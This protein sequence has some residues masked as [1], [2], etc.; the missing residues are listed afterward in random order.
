MVYAKATVTKKSVVK[1]VV[2][3]E[4][5]FATFKPSSFLLGNAAYTCDQIDPVVKSACKP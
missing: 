1:S 4:A 2:M 5:Q 3:Y